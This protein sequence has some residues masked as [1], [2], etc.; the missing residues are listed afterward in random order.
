MERIPKEDEAFWSDIFSALNHAESDRDYYHAIVEGSW[1]SADEVI[2]KH[3][4]KPSDGTD[5]TGKV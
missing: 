3:R 1:P 4:A 2:A 5:Q